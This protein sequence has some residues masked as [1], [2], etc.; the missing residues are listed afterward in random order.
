MN[1]DSESINIPAFQRKR[2]IA[3]K[4]KKTT[5][6]L[7]K[8]RKSTRKQ[9]RP[10]EMPLSEEIQTVDLFEDEITRAKTGRKI[11]EFKRC[12]ICE[13]YYKKINVAII[14]L[15]SPLR[16]SDTILIENEYGLFEQDVKSM[17]IDRK[18]VSLARTGS[19]IGIKIRK[20]AKVGT[21][22]YKLI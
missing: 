16:T 12:G 22:V 10:A 2:S 19:D 20:N 21:T 7:R 15:T 5:I 13:G 14:K 8:P 1:Q 18:D 9:L 4:A 11:R 3:A 17:Q 6:K